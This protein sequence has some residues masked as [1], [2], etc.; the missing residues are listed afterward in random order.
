MLVS[1]L[2][3]MC[4]ISDKTK[5]SKVKENW[6]EPKISDLAAISSPNLSEAANSCH[7]PW[8]MCSNPKTCFNTNP[9]GAQRFGNYIKNKRCYFLCFQ[10]CQQLLW[11]VL[12]HQ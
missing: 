3:K 8:E 2:F 12:M 6:L 1:A 4:F 5:V 10:M 7:V 9:S 11:A